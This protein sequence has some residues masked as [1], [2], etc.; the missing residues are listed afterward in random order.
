VPRRPGPPGDTPRVPPPPLPFEII[1][2][3]LADLPTLEPLWVAVHHRH[4]E[5]MPELR[6]YVSDEQTW[7]MRRL[8]Y[9]EL[10][11]KD[12]TIL[13]LARAHG[14]LV[15]YGLAHVMAVE[16]MWVADTWTTGPRIGEIESL[17][18]RPE[19]RG[20]GIG[21]A[22]LA[23]LEQAL[24]AQ[25]VT[26]LVLGVLPG[27]DAAIRLYERR[28]YRPTWMYLSRFDRGR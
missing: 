27:N 21:T 2:G 10:V 19:S 25:G 16:D 22:L 12:D 7:A 28:G 17:S 15:G 11:A 14:V 20:A 6:P 5:S 18:V 3:S 13:L 26:D 8:L 1:R 9:E 4:E 23:G 24:A